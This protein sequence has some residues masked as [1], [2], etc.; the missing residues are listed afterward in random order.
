MQRDIKLINGNLL[1]A[2]KFTSYQLISRENRVNR[3][4]LY[5]LFGG[6]ETSVGHAI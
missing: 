5:G 6:L 4:L 2:Y 1:T 3:P